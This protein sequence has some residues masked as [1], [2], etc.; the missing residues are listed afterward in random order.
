MRA[1]P[2]LRR[3]RRV[4][5]LAVMSCARAAPEIRTLAGGTSVHFRL[6]CPWVAKL[7]VASPRAL[8]V[9][10]KVAVGHGPVHESRHSQQECEGEVAGQLSNSTSQGSTSRSN[11]STDAHLRPVDAAQGLPFL[12]RAAT[13]VPQIL[14]PCVTGLSPEVRGRPQRLRSTDI[15]DWQSSARSGAHAVCSIYCWCVWIGAS[16]LI[17]LLSPRAF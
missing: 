9:Q 17:L 10:I 1:Q 13:R 14:C 6:R 4:Q 2:H 3:S 15:Y 5:E 8:A 11:A 16:S 12:S 7:A